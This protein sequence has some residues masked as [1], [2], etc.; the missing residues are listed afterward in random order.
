MRRKGQ[1]SSQIEIEERE[2]GAPK[3]IG[4]SSEY[5]L[6]RKEENKGLHDG[7]LYVLLSKNSLA[8][9]QR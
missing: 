4:E 5:G 2:S 6:P 8:F 3:L 1:N 9:K 7:E